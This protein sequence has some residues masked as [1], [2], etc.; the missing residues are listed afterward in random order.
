MPRI[1]IPSVNRDQT[2]GIVAPTDIEWKLI[3]NAHIPFPQAIPEVD[4]ER[5]VSEF[6]VTGTVVKS[7]L[8]DG[9]YGHTL[10]IEIGQVD[11]RRLQSC[12]QTVPNF[13]NHGSSFKWPW[14]QDGKPSAKVT[15]KFVSKDNVDEP[16]KVVWDGRNLS[17]LADIDARQPISY[18]NVRIGNLVHVEFT[19]IVWEY[20][21]P[22]TTE[23]NGAKKNPSSVKSVKYGCSF[24]LLS[25]GLLNDGY[26][27]YNIDSP[28]KKRRMAH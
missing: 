1:N 13:D 15:A 28:T 23:E 16:F 22:E 27:G 4:I 10:Q 11:R 2:T 5:D 26:V 6:A 3:D 25:I 17:N 20:K 12:I 21:E 19:L 7:F 14:Y 8:R 18:T 9:Q 24:K